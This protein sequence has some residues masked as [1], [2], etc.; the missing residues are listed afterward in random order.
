MHIKR[1]LEILE[2]CLGPLE[3][4]A[5][6]H[7]G[8]FTHLIHRPKTTADETNHFQRIDADIDLI[9]PFDLPCIQRVEGAHHHQAFGVQIAEIQPVGPDLPELL[10]KRSDFRNGP[11]ISAFDDPGVCPCQQSSPIILMF[12]VV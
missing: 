8:V 6:A 7:S 9:L 4:L 2:H 3:Y 11:T 1:Q 12:A 10:V 5:L